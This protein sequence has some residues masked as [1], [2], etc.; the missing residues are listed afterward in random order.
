MG[1][2]CPRRRSSGSSRFSRSAQRSTA[3]TT[4]RHSRTSNRATS[5]RSSATLL[6]GGGVHASNPESGLPQLAHAA[7]CLVFLLSRE[8]GFDS[9][10]DAP[11]KFRLD[12]PA[13]DDDEESRP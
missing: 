9:P 8:T 3:R 6:P 11:S 7:C 2:S 10:L 12:N 4:G 13:L 1:Y 5:P